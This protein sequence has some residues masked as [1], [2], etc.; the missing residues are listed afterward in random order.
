M[1]WDRKG[2]FV[3]R[4][5][6][7]LLVA[8]VVA[9]LG[10]GLL[11]DAA[12]FDWRQFEG[13]TI[14]V[15]L[16]R[17]PWQEAIEPLI[18]EFE[19]KTGIRVVTEVYPEDQFR[20]KLTV[21]L[22]SRV[23]QVDVTMVMPQND[24]LRWMHEDWIV[25][26]DDF[27][28]DENLTAPE[29]AP[30]DFLEAAWNA[31]ITTSLDPNAPERLLGIPISIENTAL[32]YRRDLF[33]KYG[34]PVPTTMEEV[35]EAAAALH[36]KDGVV[37]IVM[38]GRRAA[39]TS[40]WAAFLWSHGGSWLD[41][42]GRAAIH[43]PEAVQAFET[44]GRLLREY[45]PPGAVGYHWYE[46]TTDFATG[47][48]AM[49]IGPNLFASIYEDPNQSQ[50]AG[51]VGY[52]LF[53]AGPAGSVP[54]VGVWSLTIPYL[55]REQEAAWLFIQWATSQDVVRRLQFENGVFGARASAWEDPAMAQVYP[56]DLMTNV[57]ESLKVASP[58]WNPPV[59]PVA[60]VRD[61]VGEVIVA[62]IEGRDVQAAAD[63]A[64]QRINSVL[65][66]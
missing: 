53:P 30:G 46:V 40:Q 59:I 47:R 2:R 6:F 51:K 34:V 58:Q 65:G 27:L 8:A 11:A 43:H 13:R 24:S 4:H 17:H 19:A 49:T 33:E 56:E 41:D 48:A 55:S 32:M 62:A 38:R 52:Q 45:G 64:A 1:E 39:A 23:A 63:S 9:V 37:G 21:E 36:G 35:A 54:I 26:L 7:R 28:A 25:Y 16:N 5:I 29:F 10:F 61:L 15:L 14:R 31:N 60:E 18:P 3:V 42:E 50:V 12:E 57:L 22:A 20:A 66:R 44:Y